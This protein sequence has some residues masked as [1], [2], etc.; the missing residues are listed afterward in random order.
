MNKGV[1]GTITVPQQIHQDETDSDGESI[2]SSIKSTVYFAVVT[3]NRG[4]GIMGGFL[5][6]LRGLSRGR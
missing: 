5:T 2:K 4:T 3:T 1:C 6:G